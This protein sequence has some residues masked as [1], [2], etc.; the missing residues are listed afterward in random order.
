MF[1]E[2]L[3]KLIT[4]IHLLNY[5]DTRIP[6]GSVLCE[7]LREYRVSDS[8]PLP[9]WFTR[10]LNM[11]LSRIEGKFYFDDLDSITSSI[12]AELGDQLEWDVDDYGEGIV[13]VFPV[14]KMRVFISTEARTPQGESACS[15][16]IIDLLAQGQ[17]SQRL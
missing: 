9:S 17:Q 10:L 1:T 2:Q 15:C 5:P 11:V 12:I 14:S 16:T 13:L 4:D 3:K 6:V 8:A 7:M